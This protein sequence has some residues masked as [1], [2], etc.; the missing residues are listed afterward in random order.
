MAETRR[1]GEPS[2]LDLHRQATTSRRPPC[3]PP[4]LLVGK[5][6]ARINSGPVDRQRPHGDPPAQ[7]R[8]GAHGYIPDR[9]ITLLAEHVR[10]YRPGDDPDRRLFPGTRNA[11]V[12]AHAATVARSWRIARDAVG[13]GQP[14]ARPAP[15]VRLRADPGGLR[16]GDHPVHTRALVGGDH[17][18]HVLA[19]VAGR[20]R[21]HA[22]GCQGAA[23]GGSRGCCGPTAD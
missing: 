18:R 17:P 3:S 22:Q 16:R 23:G 15:L 6:G 19:P 20:Q 21:P 14:A 13:I 11:T 10:R 8:L 12:P 5:P 7:V 4:D 2:G 1:T 9:L